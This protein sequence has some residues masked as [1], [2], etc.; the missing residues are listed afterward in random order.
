VFLISFEDYLANFF[1]TNICKYYDNRLNNY[2]IQNSPSPH[3]NIFEFTLD[4]TY[5]SHNS[6]LEI[7]LNQMGDRLS[8]RHHKD[9]KK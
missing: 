1:R 5:F 3:T 9:P 8:N 6:G 2:F 4:S 7:T